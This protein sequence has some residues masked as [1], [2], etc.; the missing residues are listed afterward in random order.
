MTEFRDA[1]GNTIVLSGT[2]LNPDLPFTGQL[3][4]GGAITGSTL[5]P[6][7]Q[8]SL[9]ISDVKKARENI[10]DI[11]IFGNGDTFRLVCKASS[12]KQ[13]WMKSTKACNVPGGCI[14]QVTTQ[15][16]NPDGSWA[17]AEALTFV[18]MV[19][20]DKETDPENPKFIAIPLSYNFTD[21]SSF[22]IPTSL[23][24]D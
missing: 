8:K 11:K 7:E 5:T 20:L 24:L 22:M 18:P 14:V 19:H 4:N 23:D 12:E 15:Q 2:S 13:G 17:V 6:P 10:S 1:S 16:K 3:G 21:A 9:D